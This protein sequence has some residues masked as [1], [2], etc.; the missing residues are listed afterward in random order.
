VIYLL[1]KSGSMA[2]LRE[3]TELLTSDD[4]TSGR[5]GLG[6]RGVGANSPSKRPLLLESYLECRDKM[7]AMTDSR[8]GKN[9]R[10]SAKTSLASKKTHP[11]AFEAMYKAAFKNFNVATTT[12]VPGHPSAPAEAY[13]RAFASTSSYFGD[14]ALDELPD[15]LLEYARGYS[16]V[17]A[18]TCSRSGKVVERYEEMYSQHPDYLV[19][20]SVHLAPPPGRGGH[21]ADSDEEEGANAFFDKLTAA[22]DGSPFDGESAY[23]TD[24]VWGFHQDLFPIP[25][26]SES[27]SGPPSFRESIEVRTAIKDLMSPELESSSAFSVACYDSKTTMLFGILSFDEDSPANLS[28][29]ISA[30]IVNPSYDSTVHHLE[31]VFL[32]LDRLFSLGYRRIHAACDSQHSGAIKFLTNI[33]FTSEGVRRKDTLIG[34]ISRDSAVLSLLNSEWNSRG[35]KTGIKDKLFKVIY[36]V[37]AAGG[38]KA[39]KIREAEADVKAAF[40]K[41]KD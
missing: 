31:A 13:S 3:E 23:E 14:L 7:V 8:K 35:Q 12:T 16:R 38:D 29:R 22:L 37:A 28:I 40:L 18:S 15:F 4:N 32:V 20:A 6:G 5:P 27:G 10:I 34:E 24:D 33:G 39:A 26:S 30:I 17:Y 41:K 36:G 2:R 19:G 25:P 21:A 9:K 11:K 1:F